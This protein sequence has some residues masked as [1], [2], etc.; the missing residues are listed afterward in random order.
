MTTML[1][2]F[3]G[4]TV[5]GLRAGLLVEDFSDLVRILCNIVPHLFRKVWR[6]ISGALIRLLQTCAISFKKLL[7]FLE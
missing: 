4:E 6:M 1:V 2:P 5:D 7:L 3:L